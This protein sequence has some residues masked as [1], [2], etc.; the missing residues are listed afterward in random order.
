M[1]PS[2]CR[3]VHSSVSRRFSSTF[4]ARK[5]S[6][7]SQILKFFGMPASSWNSRKRRTPSEWKVATKGSPPRPPP[8]PPPPGGAG[9]PPP[10]P[11]RAPAGGGRGG[12]PLPRQ[13]VLDTVAHFAGS[14]IREG[15][16]KY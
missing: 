1:A 11:P 14:L 2:I 7:R 4:T 10:P 9:A 15:D 12:G 6:S 16:C 13:Q 5:L 8:P 3:G